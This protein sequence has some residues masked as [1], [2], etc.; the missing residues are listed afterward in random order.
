M[1]Y[2]PALFLAALLAIS[3]DS[4][5]RP[6]SP[7]SPK[8][9][10]GVSVSQ[11]SVMLARNEKVQLQATATY[12]DGSTEDVTASATWTTGNA[13]VAAVS[14]GAVT[15]SGPGKSQIALALGGKTAV[16]DV[17]VRRNVAMAASVTV[18]CINPLIS[19]L[20]A[21][22]DQSVIQVLGAESDH[23]AFEA[24]T[25][26]FSGVN[27]PPGDHT[28]DITIRSLFALVEIQA[29]RPATI[30]SAAPAALQLSDADTGERL[31]SITLSAQDV[32]IRHEGSTITWQ[33][34]VPVFDQ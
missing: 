23:Y 31:T 27:V 10:T 7:I 34:F 2:R 33:F 12:S 9:L 25:I 3:C 26:V 30:Y 19:I 17:V 4:V 15:G 1:K 13:A 5:D 18:T 8:I 11:S 28:I 22:L 20:R 29:G 21:A 32:E 16:S 6:P 24:R 14:A